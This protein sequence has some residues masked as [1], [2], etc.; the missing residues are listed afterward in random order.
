[1]TWLIVTCLS[2]VIRLFWT[3]RLAALHVLSEE[4]NQ[5]LSDGKREDE[6][7]SDDQHLWRQTLEES[8][9]AF[10]L[11]HVLDNSNAAYLG[12][13][14][15]ILDSGLDDIERS[16]YSDGSDRAADGGEEVLGPSGI[17][18]VLEAK[19]VFL[20]E[21]GSSEECER[22][23]SVSSSGPAPTSVQ[24]D[25][26]VGQD[27]QEA[28]RS[29]RFRVGLTLD[30]EH[31]QWQK[32][33]LSDSGQ[34]TGSG[35]HDG[36]ARTFTEQRFKLLLV[37][38]SEVIVKVRLSSKLVDSLQHFVASSVSETWKERKELGR[39]VGSRFVLEHDLRHR[40]TRNFV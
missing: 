13:K 27:T 16:S 37:I 29:E 5:T 34:R 15:G 1:M 33:D 21:S 22:A 9:E 40:Q 11:D 26:F 35:R 7:G 6:L 4:G 30:L 36:F 19:D 39:Y 3:S 20:G 23:G 2:V 31:I 17:A 10:V 24:V 12:F 28:A 25:I 32:N 38:G 14:V 18:V 8:T